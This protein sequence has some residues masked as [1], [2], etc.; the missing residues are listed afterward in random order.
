MRSASWTLFRVGLA[1]PL[2]LVS[3]GSSSDEGPN[4]DE[5]SG[6]SDATSGAVDATSGAGEVEYNSELA[7]RLRQCNVITRGRIG[8]AGPSVAG[9]C[10]QVCL[11]EESCSVVGALL[12]G[13]G[14]RDEL[15]DFSSCVDECE[16]EAESFVCDDGRKISA[17]YRCDLEPDCDD[18]EDEV[19]CDEFF[20]E[21]DDGER[22]PVGYRCDTEEDCSDG[23]DEG[24]ECASNLCEEYRGDHN[25]SGG[26]APVG[27]GG[28]GT[29]GF[30][31][32]G[33]SGSG[34]ASG[35]ASTGG[36]STG[37]ASTGGAST[38]G[39]STGGTA[40]GGSSSGGESG[41]GG[42]TNGEKDPSPGCGQKD[43]PVGGADLPL[44]VDGHD[45]YVK[46]PVDYDPDT[47]Y[48][49]MIV[50]PPT[51][52][53][54]SWSEATA[55]YEQ[56]APE[57]IRVYT[58]MASPAS[59]WQ[60]NET[61]FF[62]NL[63]DRVTD[64]YCIDESRIFAAGENSGGEFAGFVGCEYG[65]RLRGIVSGAAKM[66]GWNI[67]PAAQTCK[68]YPTAIVIW[69]ERDTVLAQPAGPAF[70]DFYRDL[71]QCDSTSTPVSGYTDLKSNCRVFDGCRA[72]S[73][74]YF[75]SHE[76]PNYSGT[77]H[78]WPDMAAAM[79]W[80]VFSQL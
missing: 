24:P 14:S 4:E 44:V 49:V 63:L 53:P 30:L 10:V 61:S 45:Y 18:G 47:A 80:G 57:S 73:S 37:G 70:R 20:F 74:T 71:N 50:F 32:S 65:D 2:F 19:E 31:A 69:S 59:G 67:D 1:T 21:C 38:G 55:G 75:C 13:G 41:G 29:G 9:Q 52:V 33:G 35:G 11:L 68:G 51:G 22:L 7:D 16:S 26:A 28:S 39:A 62:G 58:H 6:A 43:P 42:A 64:D 76:D 48:P 27:G 8:S 79:T 46:L 17:I 78:G 36:A 12:C 3:C 23:E 56:Q 60:L 5:A 66:T 40:S 25:S 15:D 34:G 72:G 54:I 77:Y